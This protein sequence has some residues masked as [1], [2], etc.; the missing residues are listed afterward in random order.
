MIT[1]EQISYIL[2]ECLLRFM[3]VQ[4]TL[5]LALSCKKM[6]CMIQKHFTEYVFTPSLMSFI[7][8]S[9]L[10]LMAV[11]LPSKYFSEF[12]FFWKNELYF[13]RR[14]MIINETRKMFICELPTVDRMAFHHNDY[15]LICGGGIMNRNVYKIHL[16]DFKLKKI[17]QLGTP[18]I[19]HHIQC[20]E[21]YIVISGGMSEGSFIQNMEIWDGLNKRVIPLPFKCTNHTTQITK[22]LKIYFLGGVDEHWKQLNDI[23]Y[24]NIE[25]GEWNTLPGSCLKPN[26]LTS[27]KKEGGGI[28]FMCNN[29]IK[30]KID[31]VSI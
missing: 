1:F 11:A 6:N 22:D 21:N 12:G 31:I 13:V 4:S 30:K 15:N 27:I 24:Y 25:S 8:W 28:M 5:S 3:D 26:I 14:N 29:K 23:N 10:T 18:R 9:R 20:S 7:R 19:G 2:G 16:T 17:F